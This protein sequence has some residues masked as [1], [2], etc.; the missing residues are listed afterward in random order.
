MTTQSHLQLF[1]GAEVSSL[2]H[3]GEITDIFAKPR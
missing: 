1:I 3:M 2:V